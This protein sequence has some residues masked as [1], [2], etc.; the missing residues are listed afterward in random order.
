MTNNN[1]FGTLIFSFF[2]NYLLNR[3]A[4]SPNTIA[5]YSD[6]IRLLINYYLKQNNKKVEQIVIEDFS[7]DFV[8]DFL[9]AI[10]EK[11]LPITRNQRLAA[12]KTFF[13][14]LAEQ[15][16]ELIATCE[17]ICA[18]PFKKT[19]HKIINSMDERQVRAIINAANPAT[20]NGARDRAIL[21]FLYNTGARVQELVDLNIS[22]LYLEKESIEHVL[23]TGK[24]RKQRVVP[25]WKETVEAIQYYLT[26]RQK[27]DINSEI[28]FLN[29][30]GSRL[31]RFGIG[32]IVDKYT[33]MAEIK[34]SSL[35]RITVSPH[36]FRH[37]TALHLIQSDVDIVT[38]KEWLGHVD[39]KTTSMY[40]EINIEMKR[41]ALEKCPPPDTKK[42]KTKNW[43]Q[44]EMMKFLHD[45]SKVST[46]RYGE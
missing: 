36:V 22:H 43:K 40:V 23:L 5:S 38:V 31:T 33:K 45:L 21:L 32:Y 14:F 46:V 6:C 30:N 12:I 39:L 37:T 11:V 8:L 24:G 25:L 29:R 17:K 2:R 3:K 15:E 35:K 20:V 1:T 16:P 42:D 26:I 27:C 7:A 9:D 28:L 18:I 19:E 4:C 44:P 41:K 34:C 13:R 10:E